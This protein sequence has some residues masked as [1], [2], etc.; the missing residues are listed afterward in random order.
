MRSSPTS[1]ASS[2]SSRHCLT[3]Q[4]ERRI[5]VFWGNDA[6][7]L[8]REIAIGEIA[9]GQAGAVRLGVFHQSHEGPGTRG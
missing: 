6:W 2:L 8:M 3:N 4:V 9:R 7:D 5:D 1:S